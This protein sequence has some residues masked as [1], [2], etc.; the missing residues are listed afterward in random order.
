MNCLICLKEINAKTTSGYHSKCLKVL[1]GTDKVD[2]TLSESRRDLVMEM[3]RQTHGFSISGVQMKCQLAIENGKLELV[4]NGGQ[5]IMKPSP[6][7]YPNVA[8]NEHATLKLMDRIG[9]EVPPCGL[10]RLADGHLVFVI[11]RYDRS[12][13]DGTKYHQEDAM[14]ALGIANS[15]SGLKYTAASYEEVLALVKK[16]GGD[17]V[18][19]SLF[20]RLAFSYLVGNDDHHLKNISFLHEPTFRL[21]PCYDVLGSALY[22]SKAD[23]PMALAMLKGGDEPGYYA[24]MGNGFYSGSDFV[25]M[26]ARAGLRARALISRLDRLVKNLGLHASE[27]IQSSFMPD[28]SKPK[29]EELVKQ[30]IKFM[31]V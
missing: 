25:E 30:R 9:F 23:N 2:V 14:Q 7:E 1:F 16:H 10:I 19:A 21:A 5:F 13:L 31:T 26:G 27:V 15:D 6:E 29:Y 18:A 17:A 8:E 11:R 12:F 20:D 4:D 22:S 3:P 28:V 24:E